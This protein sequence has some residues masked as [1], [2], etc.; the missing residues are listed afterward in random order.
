MG[1]A[2]GHRYAAAAFTRP[3]GRR[4]RTA[5]APWHDCT[6][7]TT[8][9]LRDSPCLQMSFPWCRSLG[10][11]LAQVTYMSISAFAP[12]CTGCRRVPRRTAFLLHTSH[13]GL[14]G[15]QDLNFVLNKHVTNGRSFPEDLTLN[16]S[17]FR[18]FKLLVCRLGEGRA[19]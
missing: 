14:A 18:L 10:L 9:A 5:I 8:A 12:T 19:E 1:P 2:P 3:A 4:T 7:A 11:N 15:N 13:Y 16:R 17:L 6:T